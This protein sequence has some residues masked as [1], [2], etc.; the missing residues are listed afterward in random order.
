MVQW[1]QICGHLGKS[2]FWAAAA[3]RDPI[4]K[5]AVIRVIHAPKGE[6][7]LSDLLPM[8]LPHMSDAAETS[9]CWWYSNMREN[10]DGQLV[11]IWQQLAGY[12]PGCGEN[13]GY[14]FPCMPLLS[15]TE[16]NRQGSNM[17]PT[18]TGFHPE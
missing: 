3:N 14:L 7:P 8:I 6:N 12:T 5:C 17:T 10:G 13:C 9:I 18:F 2:R 1:C 16:K 4:G 15:A 11:P